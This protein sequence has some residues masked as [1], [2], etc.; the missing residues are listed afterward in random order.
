MC[1]IAAWIGRK[2][3]RPERVQTMLTHIAPR[4]RDACGV[5]LFAGGEWEIVKTQGS[6]MDPRNMELLV[7]A[8]EHL[9]P[10]GVLMH[11]RAATHGSPY[12]PCN[13]H[14]I[15]GD[16]SLTIHNGVV[17]VDA[18][19]E[20]AGE[21]DTEQMVRAMEAHGLAGGLAMTRGSYAIMRVDL[22]DPREVQVIRNEYSPLQ[23]LAGRYAH[24]F[25]SL[26]FRV[27][28]QCSRIV[29]PHRLITLDAQT[30]EVD[31]KFLE[32]DPKSLANHEDMPMVQA[33]E[34][35]DRRPRQLMLPRPFMG[36]AAPNRYLE[37][38]PCSQCGRTT[39]NYWRLCVA[40]NAGA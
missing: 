33:A 26:P 9:R 5:A 21:T 32:V 6:V 39:Y 18:K 38:V 40:C 28:R 35:A 1:G 34:A 20:A 24:L 4:G 19:F 29:A 2:P 11:V 30:L 36:P 37:P 27:G 16:S 8:V 10:T 7:G 17:H 13:N 3:A 15:F 14:P 22:A 31:S 23:W 25:A 12:D